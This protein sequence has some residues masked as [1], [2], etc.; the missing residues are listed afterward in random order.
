MY[1]SSWLDRVA[2]RDE[3]RLQLFIVQSAARAIE[4]IV[5]GAELVQLLLANAFAVACQDL[6]TKLT[7]SHSFAL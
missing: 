5:A 4:V 3:A 7:Q 2:D 6:N 1:L